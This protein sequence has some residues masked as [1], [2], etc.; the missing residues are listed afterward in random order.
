[1]GNGGKK[2]FIIPSAAEATPKI[3]P[4]QER[5]ASTNPKRTKNP[6]NPFAPFLGPLKTFIFQKLFLIISVVFWAFRRRGL[7]IFPNN[8]E[9]EKPNNIISKFVAERR[10]EGQDLLTS[11]VAME[12]ASSWG[13]IL[14][15]VKSIA[16]QTSPLCLDLGCVW[17][18]HMVKAGAWKYLDFHS[19]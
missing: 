5:N 17:L 8:T 10:V 9:K 15:Q 4:F 18:S 7:S 14:V 19:T 12:G 16:P 6:L 3:Q 11:G 1:M 2:Y 13:I